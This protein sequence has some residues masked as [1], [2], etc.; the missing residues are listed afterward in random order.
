MSLSILIAYVTKYGSTQEVAEAVAAALRESGQTVVVR[1]LRDV[2]SLDGFDAVIV[3]AA[4]YMYHLNKDALRFLSRHRRELGARPVAVFA[5]GPVRD[6]HDEEEWRNSGDQLQKALDELPGFKPVAV[7]LFGGRF[8]PRLLSFPMNK[9][10]GSEPATDIRDW[11]AIRD[12]AAGLVDQLQ[13]G[14]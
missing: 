14:G 11:D 5:L 9:F 1:P 8:D 6:P 10:A 13:P 4:L 3:G 2:K 7:R 12:W